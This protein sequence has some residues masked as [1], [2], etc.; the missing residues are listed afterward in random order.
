MECLEQRAL[1]SVTGIGGETFN[2]A[3]GFT[4][5]GSISQT[6]TS[7]I[8][9]NEVTV[10]LRGSTSLKNGTITYTSLTDG[11]IAEHGAQVSGSGTFTVSGYP[12]TGN[13]SFS[14]YT[15][16]I[17]DEDGAVSGSVEITK[18]SSTYSGLGAEEDLIGT[19]TISQGE[20]D[21]SDFSL[22]MTIE[23]GETTLPLKEKVSFTGSAFA[24]A[25]TPSWNGDGSVDVAVQ[26]TGKPHT[27][28]DRGAAVGNVALY[29]SPATSYSSKSTLATADTIPVYWNEATGSYTV[30]GLNDAPA[31]TTNLLVVSNID[32]KAKALA[33]MPYAASIDVTNSPVAE[34]DAGETQQAVFTVS[35]PHASSQN[36]TVTY[37]TVKGTANKAAGTLGA[38]PGVD[39]GDALKKNKEVTG[40]LVI[41]P[42]STSGEISIPVIG[43]NTYET[44]ETFSVKLTKVQNAGLDKAHAQATATI[45]NDDDAPTISIDDV[46]KAEGNTGTTKFTFTVTLS[47]PSY[48]P[49][50]VKYATAGVG[51][52]AT[53]TPGTDFIA[54]TKPILLTIPAGQLTKTFTISVK[55]DKVVEGNEWFYVDLSAPTN[56]TILDGRGKGTITSDEVAAAAKGVATSRDA[57][58]GQLA[59]YFDQLGRSKD[60]KDTAAT[61]S[62]LATL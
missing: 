26:V 12:G 24:V 3:F 2:K 42:G 23:K 44:D 6:Y 40:S 51:T 14:G 31:G 17:L 46:T 60:K 41:P 32:G 56:A 54:V 62:V 9:D 57:A 18:F 53:A 29:W 33:A 55:G 19:Y 36:V 49:V 27:T 13:W 30:D 21:T 7:E 8:D 5:S 38:T 20:F 37:T 43:D 22:D 52:D 50:T 39:Y 59:G 25:A 45:V 10:A 47:N 58:L 28:A 1:L 48:Q 4:A 35:L 15:H 11:V 61:D 34:G 16:E